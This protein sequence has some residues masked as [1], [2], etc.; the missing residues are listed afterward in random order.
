MQCHVAVVERQ[1]VCLKVQH[2]ARLC[3]LSCTCQQGQGR[4]Q[5][6][7]QLHKCGTQ[8]LSSY[9]KGSNASA[10]FLCHT[11]TPGL[12]CS[13]WCP[14]RWTAH[15]TPAADRTV[16]WREGWEAVTGVVTPVCLPLHFLFAPHKLRAGPAACSG[17]GGGFDRQRRR[18]HSTAESAGHSAAIPAA[19]AGGPGARDKPVGA[20]VPGQP[21]AGEGA[22]TAL[23]LLG[24]PYR[25]QQLQAV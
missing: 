8:H 25:L 9:T 24:D 10:H 16:L 23:G 17:A 14:P 21:V 5:S 2:A 7:L 1:L 11:Q 13:L 6:L 20:R 3:A 4:L 22:A 19:P 18:H 15:C 12:P